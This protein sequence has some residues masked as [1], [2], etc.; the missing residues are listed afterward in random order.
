MGTPMYA[1]ILLC[2]FRDQT[3][4]QS[5]GQTLTR[6]LIEKAGL[7]N[8]ELLDAWQYWERIGI[9]EDSKKGKGSDYTDFR[10]AL[11]ERLSESGN[12][13][14]PSAILDAYM[15]NSKPEYTLLYLRCLRMFALNGGSLC[16][17]I[18]E[19]AV[20]AFIF[21]EFALEAV[22]DWNTQ[23]VASVFGG[24]EFFLVEFLPYPPKK[25]DKGAEFRSRICDL[26]LDEIKEKAD[27]ML[28]HGMVAAA[29]NYL[30]AF[31]LLGM[32]LV[33][34]DRLL[35]H[36]VSTGTRNTRY[37]RNTG[38]NWLSA[39]LKTVAEVDAL[40]TRALGSHK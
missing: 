29:L 5:K 28:P 17:T 22:D 12:T 10:V 39:E 4:P 27:R 6:R 16:A 1:I 23:G 11:P 32:P 31:A 21:K 37:M 14:L 26:T 8:L 30:T 20:N 24:G 34:V 7:S 19:F 3:M 2:G 33:V 40:L 38:M 9:A 25:E 15:V 36:C 18:G 35:S 13:L